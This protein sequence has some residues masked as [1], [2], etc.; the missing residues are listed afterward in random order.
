M[1]LTGRPQLEKEGTR[2]P[3]R[4]RRDRRDTR[5]QRRTATATSFA[6]DH[7][8]PTSTQRPATTL[9]RQPLY[10]PQTTPAHD[11]VNADTTSMPPPRPCAA[12]H[13]LTPCQAGFG[14]KFEGH[15]GMQPWAVLPN[16]DTYKSKYGPDY[17]IPS[18]FHGISFGRA[19]KFGVTAGGFGAVA[20]IFALFFFSDVPKVRNDIM[21]KI[22]IIGE[23]WVKEIAPEDNPF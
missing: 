20:G 14:T 2:M 22:P 16:Y 6:A 1:A 21:Q 12:G 23:H 19:V 3:S 7:Q 17:K 13:T 15:H 18:H 11:A 10:T 8:R 4:D 9:A 5:R